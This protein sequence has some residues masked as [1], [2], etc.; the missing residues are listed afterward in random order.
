LFIQ[1]V[2][3]KKGKKLGMVVN[4]CNTSTWEVEA[5]GWQVQSSLGYLARPCPKIMEGGGR[6]K[7]KAQKC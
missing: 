5:V 4:V 1:Q 3:K 2:I 7:V 6:E